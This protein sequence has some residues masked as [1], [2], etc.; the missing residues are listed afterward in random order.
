MLDLLTNFEILAWIAYKYRWLLV[1]PWSL[2]DKWKQ[3]IDDGDR[4]GESRVESVDR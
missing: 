2:T 4:F 3:K 1:G